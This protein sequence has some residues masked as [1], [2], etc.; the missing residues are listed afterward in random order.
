MRRLGRRLGFGKASEDRIWCARTSWSPARGQPVDHLRVVA[1]GLLTRQHRG[2][3]LGSPIGHR[4]REDPLGVPTTRRARRR[5]RPRT[6]S[7]PL[8]ETAAV[9]AAILVAGHATLQGR[10]RSEASGPEACSMPTNR[11]RQ[12]RTGGSCQHRDHVASHTLPM[13][14]RSTPAAKAPRVSHDDAQGARAADRLGWH[15]PGDK[16][17]ATSV[18]SAHPGGRRERRIIARPA[19]VVAR[20]FRTRPAVKASGQQVEGDG[21]DD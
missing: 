19:G 10:Q 1:A 3:G 12:G 6:H 15:R 20:M 2:K 9:V 17:E 14:A 18:A 7:H 11:H 16:M 4:H 21:A 8:L 13:L 5:R